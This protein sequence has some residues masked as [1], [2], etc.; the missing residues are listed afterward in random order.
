[1]SAQATQPPNDNPSV[2]TAL[3]VEVR[4]GRLCVFM[5]PTDRL[6][7]YLDILAAVGAGRPPGVPE[8]DPLPEPR[9][10]EPLN[11]GAPEQSE[12]QAQ[13]QAQA[14][15]DELEQALLSRAEQAAVLDLLTAG[16]FSGVGDWLRG[17]RSPHR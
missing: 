15:S 10:A 9:T 14:R 13:E 16:W 8:V 2:R 11:T 7:D 6:E 17:S 12:T 1:M 5:P 4:H 3:A